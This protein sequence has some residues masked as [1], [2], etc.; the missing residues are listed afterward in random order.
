MCEPNNVSQIQTYQKTNPQNGKKNASISWSSLFLS[1]ELI[2]DLIYD[3]IK[4]DDNIKT[5]EDLGEALYANKQV[6]I[7]FISLTKK[8]KKN[9]FKNNNQKY[10]INKNKTN[11]SI[12]NNINLWWYRTL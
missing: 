5:I 9:L 4:A 1:S 2:D 12:N 7:N 3:S 10:I 6:C 8:S 11:L